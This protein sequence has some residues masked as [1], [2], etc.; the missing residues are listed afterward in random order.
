MVV[1]GTMTDVMV[2]VVRTMMDTM[3]SDQY[4]IPME[5]NVIMIEVESV[6]IIKRHIRQRIN[7][8]RL[9]VVKSHI[10]QRIVK[11]RID[12]V[13]S[14]MSQWIEK[15]RIDVIKEHKITMQ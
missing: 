7:L 4:I 6:M 13:K 11:W 8:W 12:V 2:M 10:M 1:V 3:L 14:R 9:D 5:V 15:W